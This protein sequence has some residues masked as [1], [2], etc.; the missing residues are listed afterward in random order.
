MENRR[1]QASG[2]LSA[3]AKLLVVLSRGSTPGHY[4]LGKLLTPN[5]RFKVLINFP[6][7]IVF[8]VTAGTSLL[9]VF[10]N[11]VFNYS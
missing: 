7:K 8:F 2:G 6:Q 1:A 5:F 10:I 11:I 3:I 9:S 4:T